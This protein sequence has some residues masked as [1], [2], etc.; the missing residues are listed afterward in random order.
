[1][2][3]YTVLVT[4]PFNSGKST[5]IKTLGGRLSIDLEINNP[6]KPTTTVFID[7]G[8]VS[9][10][11]VQ[12][13]LYGT[14]GQP[15]FKP[16]ILGLLTLRLD[17]IIMLVDSS[18]P[19]GLAMG[20]GFYRMVRVRRPEVPMVV[21]ANKRDRIT[22]APLEEVRR[23]VGVE[24]DVPVVP[25]VATERGSVLAVLGLALEL[26]GRRVGN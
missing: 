2:R 5:F 22:A 6:V 8:A 15:R 21:A 3:R 19:A 26:A 12:V 10:D 11:G 23:R 7:Y 9:H 25:V 13:A 17:A 16:F 20:R 4:G 14:P 18:D 1:M 24:P